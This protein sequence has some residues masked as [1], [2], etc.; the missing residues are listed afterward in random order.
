MAVEHFG[1][2]GLILL[3]RDDRFITVNSAAASL[4]KLIMTALAG[5]CFSIE[6][7][8]A[9]LVKH[10][11]LT[12]SQGRLKARTILTSWLKEGLLVDGRSQVSAGGSV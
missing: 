1:N 9:L 12:D 10:Y 2:K 11:R 3:A 6:D 4:L 7:V 8:A 5:R